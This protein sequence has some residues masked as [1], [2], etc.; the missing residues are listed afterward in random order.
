MDQNPHQREVPQNAIPVGAFRQGNIPT[1][2]RGII[3]GDNVQFG[4]LRQRSHL[5][6][7]ESSGSEYERLGSSA[8]A[9]GS[10]GQSP[11]LQGMLAEGNYQRR[12]PSNGDGPLSSSPRSPNAR[13]PLTFHSRRGQDL[14]PDQRS[15]P[16]VTT[17]KASGTPH[18][19]SGRVRDR[20]SSET[21]Q[22]SKGSRGAHPRKRG[23]SETESKPRWDKYDA[24]HT[25]S[26]RCVF[27]LFN[28]CLYFYI[29]F[30]L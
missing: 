10:Y 29:C 21:E 30:A 25:Q 13:G 19:Q 2:E 17:V 20:A 23:F 24:A 22:G 5:S 12:L 8:D 14:H 28:N 16:A 26:N 27:G 4:R 1:V 9:G 3:S 18:R 6:H 15:S 11:V 7:S